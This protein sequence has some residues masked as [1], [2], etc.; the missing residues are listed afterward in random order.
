MSQKH[1]I[2]C[3]IIRM[4]N[5]YKTIDD[6]IL[7]SLRARSSASVI[8]P[9]HF[10][11]VGSAPAVR[12]ALS[13]LVK[14][15]KIRRIRRGLYDLPRSHP[16]MGQTQPDIKA[17]VRALMEGSQAQWQFSGAYAANALGLSEQVPAK[18]VVLTNGASRKVLLGKLQIVFRHAGPRN[19]LGA[20][21]AAGLV[22][23]ALRYLKGSSDIARHVN[24]LKRK[25]DSETKS[26]LGKLAPMMPAW[27][28][29]L[30]QTILKR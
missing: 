1:A 6:T 13:R 27:M 24:Y 11:G 4:R 9:K 29:P 26:E 5:N 18:I 3:D 28:Q 15:G 23:Q 10:E 30:V 16:V 17:A 22:F 12:Q 14:S 8:N 7:K 25:L 19:L 21:H 20:G 2:V